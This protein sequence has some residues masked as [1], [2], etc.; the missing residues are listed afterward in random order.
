MI[1]ARKAYYTELPGRLSIARELARRD[2]LP[3][4]EEQKYPPLTEEELVGER[5]AKE[6]KWRND[7]QGWFMTKK[8]SKVTWDEKFGSLKVLDL[9]IATKLTANIR[10]PPTPP[11]PSVADPSTAAA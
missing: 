2:R 5:L 8:G 3:T 9:D 10:A 11:A 4:K 6:K 7:F 1:S